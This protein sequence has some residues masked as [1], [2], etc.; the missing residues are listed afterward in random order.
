M[1]AW[2]FVH[3]R[4]AKGSAL[5]C[6]SVVDEYTRE[7]LELKMA[8]SIKSEDVIDVLA[9]L[10][11][12]RGVPRHIR[13]DNGPEFVAKAV[14][15]WLSA[16]KVATIYI[17]PGSPWENGYAESFG[18]RLRD[19]F[20]NVEEF[21]DVREAVALAAAW[22][23]SYNRERPHSSLGYRT[24]AQF[25]ATCVPSGLGALGPSEHTGEERSLTLI[26]TGT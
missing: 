23:E 13:S 19:E 16:N 14:K 7:C 3:D 8:R 15:D 10:F 26:V 9:G 22:K 24:P 6:L 21:A 5:K 12:R 17:E 20:L 2:D 25:A 1:W 4:T 11:R 18:S